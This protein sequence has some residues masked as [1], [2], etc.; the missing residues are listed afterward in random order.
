MDDAVGIDD[1]AGMGGGGRDAD[2]GGSVEVLVDGVC[3]G[4]SGVLLGEGDVEDAVDDELGA[5]ADELRFSKHKLVGALRVRR[6]EK[7]NEGVSATN[8]ARHAVA[9]QYRAARTPYSI[10]QP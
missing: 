2:G 1:V 7:R 3:I 9:E 4:G 10:V 5:L 6:F 8:A